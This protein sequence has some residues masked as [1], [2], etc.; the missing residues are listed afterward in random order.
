[1]AERTLDALLVA[2]GVDLVEQAQGDIATTNKLLGA[3]L[4]KMQILI[5]SNGVAI[6]W[7]TFEVQVPP[8]PRGTK[9]VKVEEGDLVVVTITNWDRENAEP[10]YYSQDQS[11]QPQGYAAPAA[12]GELIR[13][14][15][16]PLNAGESKLLVLKST[17]WGIQDAGT[18]N[19]SPILVERNSIRRRPNRGR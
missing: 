16:Y 6:N 7:D 5:V 3:L 14:T 4:E 15:G 8:G 2:L 9:I 17:L 12:P 19:N 1:M 11:V 18:T 13:S 10:I